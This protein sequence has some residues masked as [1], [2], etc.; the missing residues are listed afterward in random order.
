M[1]SLSPPRKGAELRERRLAQV[2]RSGHNGE[3]PAGVLV[4][5][6]PPE[7][8][9]RRQAPPFPCASPTVLCPSIECDGETQGAGLRGPYPPENNPTQAQPGVQLVNTGDSADHNW[10]DATS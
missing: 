6:F 9:L 5:Q 10:A 4:S 7:L 1:A 2:S 3:V 8:A